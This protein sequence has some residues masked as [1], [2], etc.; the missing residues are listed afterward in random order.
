MFWTLCL[1]IPVYTFRWNPLQDIV[2]VLSVLWMMIYH[3]FNSRNQFTIFH[4]R[5]RPMATA[6][7]KAP[8]RCSGFCPSLRQ[9]LPKPSLAFHQVRVNINGRHQYTAK[10]LPLRSGMCFRLRMV[11][12]VNITPASL[13]T[14]YTAHA[15]ALHA[16]SSISKCSHQQ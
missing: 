4:Y 10:L 16:P 15:D 13:Q 2:T 1:F 8:A 12:D 11:S 5:Y 3:R 7:K 14:I 6:V 9:D